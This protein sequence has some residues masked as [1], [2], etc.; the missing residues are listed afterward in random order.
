MT[1]W[2]L[3]AAIEALAQKAAETGL[4]DHD[5]VDAIDNVLS[6]EKRIIAKRRQTSPD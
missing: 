5:I 6:A 4:S 3:I 2:E 1:K